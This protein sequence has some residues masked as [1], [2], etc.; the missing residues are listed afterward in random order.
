MKKLVVF[1]SLIVALTCF[2]SC[3]K[4]PE[5]PTI[6]DLNGDK[7]QEYWEDPFDVK[8]DSERVLPEDVVVAEIRTKEHLLNLGKKVSENG[9][10]PDAAEEGKEIIYLLKNDIDMGGAEVAGLDLYGRSFYGNNKIIS[11]L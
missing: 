11:N 1:F 7:V 8:A 4:G 3:K 5:A 6:I 10:I 9:P 2:W